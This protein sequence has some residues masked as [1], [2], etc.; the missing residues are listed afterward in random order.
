MKDSFNRT[1]NYLRISV[2]DRC[3]LRCVYCMP[4]EGIPLVQHD[5][6]LSYDEIIAFVKFA[7]SKGID[8]VRITGGEPLVRKGICSL[9]KELSE[10]KGLDDLSLTT[11]GILL[12]D[13]AAPLKVAGLKRINISL[14]TLN[15]DRYAELT[16]GGS[17]QTVLN[18]I[19]AAKK[20]GFFPIKLNCVLM[21]DTSIIDRLSLEKFA[22]A[23][24]LKLR[25]IHRMNLASGVFSMVEGGA[26]GDC[27]HCNRLRLTSTGDLKPCLFSNI[28]YNI[29]TLGFEEALRLAVENK[30]EKGKSNTMNS[31]YNIGG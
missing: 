4:E 9:I 24:G 10:I 22:K 2:T 28:S 7:V 13:M 12:H 29:R 25:Y 26:G 8:K 3:N 6:I 18:G 15:P 5:D 21:D 16:R 1:I 19:A 11:N 17:L 23:E 27:P 31:F 20:A 14:D 30:P